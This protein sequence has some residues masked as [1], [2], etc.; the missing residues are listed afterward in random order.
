MASRNMKFPWKFF[1]FHGLGHYRV[2][3]GG[4]N[5]REKGALSW[6]NRG[7]M[8]S[9]CSF[10]WEEGTKKNN[11]PASLGFLCES[12]MVNFFHQYNSEFYFIS[13]HQGHTP[14]STRGVIWSTRKK[15]WVPCRGRQSSHTKKRRRAF[16]IHLN[17]FLF[18][19]IFHLI[20]STSNIS[21]LSLRRHWCDVRLISGPNIQNGK[22][23]PSE[24]AIHFFLSRVFL[25]GRHEQI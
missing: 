11:R 7:R 16:R 12:E 1:V 9:I 4:M 19:P 2:L 5:W 18:N 6:K 10:N 21:F 24:N 17:K 22:T 13:R 3:G 25:P 14:Q 8:F 15:K 20:L 23:T